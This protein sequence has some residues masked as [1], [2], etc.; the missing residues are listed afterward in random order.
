MDYLG[1]ASLVTYYNRGMF[2][3][4]DYAHPVE[5][6]S[7]FS[8]QLIDEEIA[9]WY[10]TI[11]QLSNFYDEISVLQVGDQ[12]FYEFIEVD[13]KAPQASMYAKWPDSYKFSGIEI[14][15]SKDVQVI[16]RS[17]YSFL[18]WLGDIG[19]LYVIL[20]LIC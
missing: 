10:D 4:T 8:K 11:I 20:K 12:S 14:K 2:R 7:I 16:S 5:R 9:H 19:G 13:Q 3:P 18:A 17:S 15:Y 1:E 6:T